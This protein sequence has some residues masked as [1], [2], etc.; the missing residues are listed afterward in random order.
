[1]TSNS[2]KMYKKTFISLITL[3]AFAMGSYALGATSSTTDP[4]GSTTNAPDR[5]VLEFDDKNPSQISIKAH[6][7][8]QDSL[9][10]M[11]G[12]GSMAHRW[13]HYVRELEIYS[14]DGTQLKIEKRDST[15]WKVDDDLKGQQ[16]TMQYKLLIEHEKVQWPSGIDGIAFVRDWGVMASGRS[17][18]IVN[19]D[20]KTNIEVLIKKPAHWKVSTP[21]KSAAGPVQVHIVPTQIQLLESL[22]FAGT[23]EEVEIVR[24]TFKL[25]FV[26]G[27]ESIAKKKEEYVTAANNILD[28]YIE[29]MG[30]IPKPEAGNELSSVLVMINQSNTVDGEVIGNSISLLLNPDTNPQEQLLGWFIFAHEFF[31]LWNGKSLRFNDTNSDW[32]KEGISNYYT[33]KA[34][35]NAKLVDET[36]I[37]TVLNQ[38]FYQRYIN[39]P[40]LGHLAPADAASGFD[41]A[42]HWG[43]VYGGGLFTGICMDMQ[44]RHNTNN[45]RSLDDLMRHFYTKT[46]GTDTLIRNQDIVDQVEDLSHADFTEFINTYIQGTAQVPLDKYLKYAGIQVS[47]VNQQL[48]LTH[49]AVKNKLQQELWLGFLG[50]N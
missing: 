40:G 5:Y 28:Y 24:D 12:N 23:H 20:S 1:M 35:Y 10:K 6:I 45:A 47:T 46:A 50:L 3:L 43:L 33:M 22:I 9:L 32:F 49:A 19:G 7:T 4:L 18:F 11:S 48:Q 31:H 27:G 41:K 8:L 38:L 39:D 15:A 37:T 30:G 36:G 21:W 16:I 17:L 13:P 29:L 14:K 2:Q 34:L 25:K 26:L 44:I 42:N